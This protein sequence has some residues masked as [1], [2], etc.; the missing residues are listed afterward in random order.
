LKR[1]FA[2]DLDTLVS[3]TGARLM[4]R[5]GI[6]LSAKIIADILAPFMKNSKYSIDRIGTIL[7]IMSTC[8]PSIRSSE[9]QLHQLFF[10]SV[11]MAFGLAAENKSA[12]E[13]NVKCIKDRYMPQPSQLL[14]LIHDSESKNFK[15]FK[16]TSLALRVDGGIVV[17][18]EFRRARHLFQASTQHNFLING[19]KGAGKQT[20][21][22]YLRNERQTLHIPLM[23]L[24]TF[25][26]LR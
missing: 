26:S 23:R 7:D 13:L 1:P 4:K 8:N 18:N 16:E 6:K 12:L 11:Y 2:E 20:L 3:V 24:L 9:S 25:K 10:F 21:M 17:S 15:D 22:S 19:D 5:L 14:D